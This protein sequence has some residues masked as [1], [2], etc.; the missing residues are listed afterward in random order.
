VAYRCGHDG[1]DIARSDDEAM[2]DIVE[3]E[4]QNERGRPAR[5]PSGW[6]RLLHQR[7]AMNL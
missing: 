5:N 2:R 7:Y 3:E 4:R 1:L 6:W